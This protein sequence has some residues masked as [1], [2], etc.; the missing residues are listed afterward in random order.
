M[1]TVGITAFNPQQF[2]SSFH[3]TSQVVCA[4]LENIAASPGCMLRGGF[5]PLKSGEA[6]CHTLKHSDHFTGDNFYTVP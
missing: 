1:G 3:F 4:G 2:K 5:K 6:L